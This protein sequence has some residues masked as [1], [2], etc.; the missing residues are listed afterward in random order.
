[1]NR[2]SYKKLVIF[3]TL[4]SFLLSGC[5]T[6]GQPLDL[7]YKQSIKK[8]V[9]ISTMGDEFR[10]TKI[11]TTVFNNAYVKEDFSD[12][13]ING[14]IEK[15]IADYLKVSSGFD[16][17][18]RPDLR[19]EFKDS[20]GYWSNHKKSIERLDSILNAL[21]VEGVDAIMVISPADYVYPNTGIKLKNYGLVVRT[22]LLIWMA[23][24]YFKA[25]ITFI[26]I[27]SR[28]VVF[29][30]YFSRTKEIKFSKWQKSFSELRPEEQEAIKNFFN[31]VITEDIPKFLQKFNF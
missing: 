3:L 10:S 23:E 21:K 20:F 14:K 13:D 31:N 22:F 16:S 30:K 4:G 8:V 19:E 12:F 26:D 11:G 24:A 28:E 1:M 17:A 29:W 15:S 25:Y 9:I 18:G 27:S 2:S 5:A 7:T 6:I